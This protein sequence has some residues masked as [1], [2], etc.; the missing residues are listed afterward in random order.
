M[1]FGEVHSRVIELS[2]VRK[3]IRSLNQVYS[4]IEIDMQ[5]DA[6]ETFLIYEQI[7]IKMH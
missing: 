3:L 4:N 5:G 7:V 1:K 2:S 6:D